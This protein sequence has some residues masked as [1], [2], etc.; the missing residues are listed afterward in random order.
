[1]T[2]AQLERLR[3]VG[4][5]P[6]EGG[7]M[8]NAWR[9]LRKSGYV[10]DLGRGKPSFTSIYEITSDGRAVLEAHDLAEAAI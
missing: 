5:G 4:D 3:L 6:R 7:S 10:R 9:A 2:P 8:D 1:M